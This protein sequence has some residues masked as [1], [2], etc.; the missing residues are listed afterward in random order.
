M[1]IARFAI[2]A[3]PYGI[4][5]LFAAYQS[6]RPS[7]EYF[8]EMMRDAPRWPNPATGEI[9]EIALRGGG[10]GYINQSDYLLV[11]SI[12]LAVPLFMF[13]VLWIMHDWYKAGVF[14]MFSSR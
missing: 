8:N 10:S 2:A 4:V 1:K 5:A 11:Q 12:W 13:A 3:I 7:A 14:E 6:R 9:W